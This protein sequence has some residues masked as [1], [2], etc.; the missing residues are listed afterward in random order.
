M[1]TWS[2]DQW[3]SVIASL[4]AV[5]F[6]AT[7]SLIYHL[8]APWWRSEVGRNQMGF[9]AIVAALCL[10]NALATFMQGDACALWVLRTFRTLVLV[11]VSALMLQRTR[12]LLRAQ[13][14]HGGRTGV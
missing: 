3:M 14:E 9:A 7:F 11:C 4:V 2:G 12:L 1:N 13:R 5:S 10:Y 8:R 6:C